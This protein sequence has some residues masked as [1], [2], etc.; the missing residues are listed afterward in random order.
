MA[1]PHH[2]HGA[3]D[4]A[5]ERPQVSLLPERLAGDAA[6]WCALIRR[7]RRNG[8]YRHGLNLSQIFIRQ[9]D[10]KRRRCRKIVRNAASPQNQR[11]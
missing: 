8:R 3:S 5:R 1:S 4:I 10:V 11:G 7:C 6:R 9:G 2:G